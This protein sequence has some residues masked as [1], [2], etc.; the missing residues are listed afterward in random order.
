MK[1]HCVSS[2]TTY[3]VQGLV[4]VCIKCCTPLWISEEEDAVEVGA[5]HEQP[6]YIV[7]FKFCYY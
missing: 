1:E 6:C 7:T 3:P 4:G 5:G 2:W